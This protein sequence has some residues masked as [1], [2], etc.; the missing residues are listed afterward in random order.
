MGGDVSEN[1]EDKKQE[2]TVE[3]I[4]K[5]LK[6]FCQKVEAQIGL[7]CLELVSNI[8]VRQGHPVEEIL[9]SVDQEDCD[10]IV[11]ETHGK[12]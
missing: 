9:L 3:H 11:L 7:P 4:K 1:S 12:E 6:E 5:L 8:L 10:V 2:M